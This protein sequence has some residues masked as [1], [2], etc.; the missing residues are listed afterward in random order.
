MNKDDI[1]HL[2]AQPIEHEQATI[3]GTRAAL[4][5]LQKAIN[6]ALTASPSNGR[7]VGLSEFHTF[8]ADGEGYAVKI[9]ILPEEQ[10]AEDK[11]PYGEDFQKR[12]RQ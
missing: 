9:E 1:L 5:L 6:E 8:A 10:M 11:L 3:R 12:F 4:E 2:H 7:P